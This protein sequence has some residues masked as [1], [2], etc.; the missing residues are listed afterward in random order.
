M[1][2][3]GPAGPTYLSPPIHRWGAFNRM[4]SPGTAPAVKG[5]HMN[6]RV[7]SSMGTSEPEANEAHIKKFQIP[8]CF[9]L[10]FFSVSSVPLW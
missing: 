1:P 7:L 6:G 5:R 4:H 9:L 10:L 3:K 2:M 8:G